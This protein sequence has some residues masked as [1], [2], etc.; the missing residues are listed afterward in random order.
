MFMTTVTFQ[1][2]DELLEAADDLFDFLGTDTEH[3]IRMFL[4][5]AV[6]RNEIPFKIKRNL[7]PYFD[8]DWDEDYDLD[9]DDIPF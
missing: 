8:P 6:L 5:Q 3:A 7:P 1:V 4:V 9:E 2:D